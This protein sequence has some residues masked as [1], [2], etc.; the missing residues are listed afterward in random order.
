ML[1]GHDHTIYAIAADQIFRF[2]GDPSKQPVA[3]R[4]FGYRLPLGGGGE[5]EP[6]ISGERPLLA[7]PHA[8]AA[9]P[10]QPKLAVCAALD[11]YL[12][13]HE[14][15]GKLKQVAH[16]KLE[17]QEGDGAVV[18]IAGD[19]V[20][21]AQEQGQVFLLSASDLS[22]KK[23][24]VL[25]ADSQ[26]RFAKAAPDAGRI[27]LLFQNRRLWL[28]D[29]E[30]GEARRAPIAAQGQMSGLAF[31]GERLLIGDYAN[32]VVAYDAQALKRERVYQPPLSRLEV[33]YY[34]GIEPLY[35]IFPKPRMLNRTVQY[36]LTGKRT[37]DMGLFQGNLAQ[38]RDDLK[39]WQPVQSGLAFVGVILFLACIYIERHE[40]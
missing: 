25:E 23:Q 16:R 34:Y 10:Q 7:E 26:P 38:Q 31:S 20:L 12:F 40:F 27:A 13:A 17:G 8:A 5:F 11:V 18:A 24:F 21:V 1:M 32:R 29:V 14:A 3:V 30:N 15:D 28:I 2:R 33:A 36:V 4:A 37:T 6:A 22:V 39:P 9:D 19:T 35:T